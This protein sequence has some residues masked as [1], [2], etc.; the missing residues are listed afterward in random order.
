MPPRG[1]THEGDFQIAKVN[2]I[3]AG[4]KSE[5]WFLVQLYEGIREAPT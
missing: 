5:I 3:R 1:P 4:G 2:E